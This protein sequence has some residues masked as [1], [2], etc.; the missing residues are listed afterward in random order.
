MGKS[1][2]SFLSNVANKF[3]K[4]HPLN[5]GCFTFIEVQFKTILHVVNL[6]K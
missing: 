2:I 5:I 6:S 3:E 1:Y 4:K